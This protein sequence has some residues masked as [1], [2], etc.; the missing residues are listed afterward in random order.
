MFL[1]N[2]EEPVTNPS[3]HINDILAGNVY[4]RWILP[5]IFLQLNNRANYIYSIQ[6]NLEDNCPED[7]TD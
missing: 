2:T 5:Y 3:E 4:Y 6:T 1:D 7:S